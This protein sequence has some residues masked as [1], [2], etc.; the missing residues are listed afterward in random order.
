MEDPWTRWLASTSTTS[1][2]QLFGSK[3]STQAYIA[4]VVDQ[5]RRYRNGYPG[6]SDVSGTSTESWM[7]FWLKGV[8]P[9][10]VRTNKDVLSAIRRSD[11]GCSISLPEVATLKDACQRDIHVGDVVRLDVDD[12]DWYVVRRLH[13]SG[14]ITYSN[15]KNCHDGNAPAHHVLVVGDAWENST[16][17]VEACGAAEGASGSSDVYLK[18][19]RNATGWIRMLSKSGFET[20]VRERDLFC[21]GADSGDD[22]GDDSGGDSGDDSG[23]DSSGDSGGDSDDDSD[24]DSDTQEEDLQKNLQED[25]LE[26]SGCQEFEFR[27]IYKNGNEVCMR[28]PEAGAPTFTL[29][30]STDDQ[31]EMKRKRDPLDDGTGGE[32]GGERKRRETKEVE[33]V[34]PETKE[35]RRLTS[36]IKVVSPRLKNGDWVTVTG[37]PL[38]GARAEKKATDWRAHNDSITT[39]HGDYRVFVLVY[40]VGYSSRDGN[41]TITLLDSRGTLVS[42][43]ACVGTVHA[44]LLRK[45]SRNHAFEISQHPL[46]GYDE[47]RKWCVRSIV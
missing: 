36:Q 22:S 10:N 39:V 35:L 24:D 18:M 3:E 25:A 8:V 4:D 47:W 45:V 32:T 14:Q 41:T 13:C 42:D 31:A 44:D 2:I 5:G 33:R 23:G 15:A 16:R 9:D 30:R 1:E 27:N 43:G 37:N 21:T 17:R 19:R 20:N 11:Y 6:S 12:D 28:R 38:A 7:S 26:V 34:D 46:Y 29:E 40:E